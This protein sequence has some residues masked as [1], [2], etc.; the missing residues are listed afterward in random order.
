MQQKLS[1]YALITLSIL[2]MSVYLPML[3]QKVFVARTG[4]THLFYSP[5]IKK[6]VFREMIKDHRFLTR[7]ETGRDL[8]RK[9]FESLMPFIYYKNMEL[10]GLLP[11]EI[12]GQSFDK[13][14]IKANRQVIELKP[15]MIADRFPQ[16][17]IYPLIESQPDQ[18]LFIFPEDRFR[19]TDRMEF[20][21]ADRN[22]VDEAL[23][24]VFTDAL[25]DAGF[26]FPARL[27]AGKGTILKPFDEGYFVVDAAGAVF[28]IKRVRGKPLCVRTPIPANLGIRSIRIS[29]NRR[30]E[31]YG[32][33]LTNDGKLFLI[34]YDNYRLI[35][36]PV[37]NYNPDTMNYKLI[38]NPLYRTAVYSDKTMIYATAMTPDYKIIAGYKR[39]MQRSRQTPAKVFYSACFPFFVQIKD[40]TSN[41]MTFDL[42]LNGWKGFIGIGISVIIYFIFVCVRRFDL[43]A[44]WS[45]FVVIAFSGIYGLIA[46][47]IVRPDP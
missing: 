34:S 33:L 39:A 6:F 27:I 18:A 37:D 8:D 12:D 45:D 44:L 47:A 40:H 43:K 16:D 4:R 17:E 24:C 14:T 19:I 38:I 13:D 23:S 1:R 30:K 11:F 28:H 26:K 42:V 21:N 25:K 9:T 15:R 3:Y 41:Y 2:V 22:T 10:W 29:E 31:F 20:V 7:D 36:L 46:V 32:M 5:V 35:P